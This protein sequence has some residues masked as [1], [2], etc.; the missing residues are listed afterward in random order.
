MET[1]LQLLFCALFETVKV[2]KTRTVQFL[3]VVAFRLDVATETLMMV[4]RT[5]IIALNSRFLRTRRGES[6]LSGSVYG[7]IVMRVK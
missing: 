6:L 7:V 4:L 5:F 1:E 2:V 3:Q